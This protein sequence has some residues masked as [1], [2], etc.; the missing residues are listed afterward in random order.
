[1]K[2]VKGIAFLIPKA[3][4]K[5]SDLDKDSEAYKIRA[6]IAHRLGLAEVPEKWVNVCV[7]DERYQNNGTWKNLLTTS[8]SIN[9]LFHEQNEI[10]EKLYKNFFTPSNEDVD[11]L[12][13]RYEETTKEIEMHLE[14]RKA[15]YQ[16][17]KIQLFREENDKF[18]GIGFDWHKFGFLLDGNVAL[19]LFPRELPAELFNGKHDLEIITFIFSDIEFSLKI[20]QTLNG[21]A[22]LTFDE[23]LNQVIE[24]G[25]SKSKEEETPASGIFM[26]KSSIPVPVKVAL[27]ALGGLGLLLIG[28]RIFR[29]E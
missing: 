18:P 25:D 1:M 26:K 16:F 2:Q 13:M 17:S 27:V 3:T 15:C 22:D 11:R 23:V 12:I 9:L 8:N 10:I 7:T 21:F 5:T 6:G 19:E 28:C 24:D 29:K 20:N 14:K 4:K